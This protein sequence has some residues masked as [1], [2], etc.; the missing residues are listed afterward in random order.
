MYAYVYIKQYFFKVS[1]NI[2]SS[3]PGIL[4]KGYL[5]SILSFFNIYLLFLPGLIFWA[6]CSFFSCQKDLGTLRALILLE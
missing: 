2:N 1:Q 3:N 4:K 6:S 5:P